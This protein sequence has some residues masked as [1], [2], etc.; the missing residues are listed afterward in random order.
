M[1]V[2]YCSPVEFE[3]VNLHILFFHITASI[4]IFPELIIIISEILAN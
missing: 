3:N 4:F 1:K 2:F